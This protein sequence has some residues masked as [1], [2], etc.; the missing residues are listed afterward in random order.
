ML[1]IGHLRRALERRLERCS[2]E[3]GAVLAVI[4]LTLVLVLAS[5][6]IAVDLS[7][8]DRQGQSLQ[9][10]ADAAALAGATTWAQ[11]QDAALA[12][13]VV[14]D[15]IAQNG[16]NVG[17][18]ILLDVGFPSNNEVEVQLTDN[19]PE[20]MLAGVIGVGDDLVRAA[21]GKHLLCE[22]GC[23]RSLDV[24]PPL[25]PISAAGSGDG[26]I[27]ISVGNKIYSVNHHGSTIECVD[28]ATNATCWPAQQLFATPVLTMNTPHAGLI[29]DRIYYIGWNGGSGIVPSS[30]GY[31]QVG[32]WNTLIDA[33]CSGQADLFNVGHGTLYATDDAIYVFAA[34]RDVYCFEPVTFS[35]CT[36]YLGGRNTALTSETGWG[37]WNEARAWNGDRVAWNDKVYVTLSNRGA[38]WLHCWDLAVHAPCTYFAPQ[39]LNGTREGTNA[40]YVAGR[41]F[42]HRDTFGTPDAVCSFG[43]SVLVDCFELET[44]AK[45]TTPEGAM[46]STLSAVVVNA[47]SFVGVSTYH[48]ATNR[49]FFVSSYTTSTTYCHD[50]TSGAPCLTPELVNNTGL[51]LAETYGYEAQGDCLIG[52]G[53]NSI[54]FTLKPDLSGPCDAANSRIDITG[55]QCSGAN[56]W[57]PVQVGDIEGVER[58]ELRVLDPAGNLVFPE[59]GVWFELDSQPID[60]S[61]IDNSHAYL[62][63]E[64]QVTSLAGQDPWADG[65]SPNLLVGMDNSDPHLIG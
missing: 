15:V 2:N 35:E 37:L 62:T 40:D 10:G 64:V 4:A 52:L 32:C 63:L 50:F 23:F 44:A 65:V 11:T 1:W 7:A 43:V 51:G 28:R 54:F 59:E 13:Q 30:D 21:V 58:F 25:G 3:R 12:T 33:R 41:L 27:P 38:V 45:L 26:F 57:P 39:L 29:G 49:Q 6:A 34:N 20:V 17:S 9:S 8:L 56:V 48:P 47:S 61:G 5:G 36:D 14:A 31:L 46:T 42:L 53:D 16:I 60:L 18:D 22:A 19:T 24:A 55:C